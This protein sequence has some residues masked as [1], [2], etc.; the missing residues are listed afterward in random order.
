M[1][2]IELRDEAATPKGLNEQVSNNYLLQYKKLI[3]VL[4]SHFN[5]SETQHISLFIERYEFCYSICSLLSFYSVLGANFAT[6][7]SVNSYF[8]VIMTIYFLSKLV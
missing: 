7:E 5:F 3:F 2:F 1:L 6:V 8:N 4:I